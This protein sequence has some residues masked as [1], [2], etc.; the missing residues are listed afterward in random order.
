MLPNLQQVAPIWETGREP[1]SF[2]GPMMSR[3][4][5]LGHA[6][7]CGKNARPVHHH[8]RDWFQHDGPVARW[9]G[10][11]LETWADDAMPPVG[12][13]PPAAGPRCPLAAGAMPP[14]T[15]L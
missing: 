13:P 9:A 10:A 5:V 11:F 12:A 2:S 6:K 15:A 7:A 8:R 4:I 1:H 3:W 14:V